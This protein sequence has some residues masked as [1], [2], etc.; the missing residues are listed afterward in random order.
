MQLDAVEAGLA[1]AAPGLSEEAGQ[2]ARQLA[3]VG[4]VGVPDALAVAVV[5]RLPLPVV[6]RRLQQRAIGA[7]QP[8]AHGGLGRLPPRG[9]VRRLGQPPAQRRVHVQE[10]AQELLGLGPAAHGD[11]VDRLDEQARVAGAAL[12]HGLDES[13]QPGHE[14][15][16]ADAQ[17]GAAGDVAD[18]GGLDHEHARPP[19]GEARVPRQHLVGD[20]AVVRRAPRHHRRHPRPLLGHHRADARRLEEPRALRLLARGPARRRQAVADLEALGHGAHASAANPS[21]SISAPSA[22]SKRSRTPT[23]VIAGKCLPKYSR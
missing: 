15:V 22:A 16:V 12:A 5:Q 21:I 17:Q 9:V 11:E 23:S 18:A 10:S 13:A 1:G 19:L 3:D 20:E 7:H 2:H 4:Q 8:L 6:Q 14:A